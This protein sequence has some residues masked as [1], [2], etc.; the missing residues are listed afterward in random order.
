MEVSS[1]TGAVNILGKPLKKLVI[2]NCIM[3]RRREVMGQITEGFAKLALKFC[4]EK[5]HPSLTIWE[6]QQLLTAWLDRERLRAEVLYLQKEKAS[7]KEDLLE[8]EADKE[9]W[10]NKAVDRLEQL[11]AANGRVEMLAGWLKKYGNHYRGPGE[12][13]ELLKHSD[14]PCT[15]GLDAALSNLNEDSAG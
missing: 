7:L 8:L 2:A 13:C 5:K 3:E 1:T 4:E 11:A 9:E 14:Y 6:T 15:C 10:R 12:M